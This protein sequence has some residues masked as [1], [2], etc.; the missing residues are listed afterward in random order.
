[1]INILNSIKKN[2]STLKSFILQA[3]LATNIT[4]VV[5]FAVIS[6]V[7]YRLYFGVDFTDEAFYIVIP[8]RFAMGATP[9]IDEINLLQTASFIFIP[10]IKIYYWI[11]GSTEGIVLFTRRFYLT[12]MIL[13][14]S[15]TYFYFKRFIRWQ[16]A[17]L[18]SFTCVAFIPYN[19]PSFSYNTLSYSLFT[20]GCITAIGIIFNNDRP[21]YF[22]LSGLCHGLAVLAYPTI[23]IPSLIFLIIIV[24]IKKLKA[25]FYYVLGGLLIA[26]VLLPLV[27]QAG[28]DNL[29]G[30]YTYFRSFGVQG[31]SVDK[32]INTILAFWNTY[33]Y[34]VSIIS[35]LV[36]VYLSYKLNY[37]SAIYVLLLL[38]ILPLLPLLKGSYI[39]ASLLYI[40]YY[41]LLAPYLLLFFGK[42]QKVRQVFWVLWVPSFIAGLTF[43]WSS[44]NGYI[45]AGLGFFQGSLV[46]AYFIYRL[47]SGLQISKSKFH[48]IIQIISP[49]MILVTLV[50]FQYTSV[51]RDDP[52]PE[53]NTRVLAGPYSGMF[54]TTEKNQYL[55]ELSDDL[56]SISKPE[57]K[58][59]FYDRFP[60][61]YLLT[62]MIPAT[63]TCW[64]QPVNVF[65]NL[66]RQLNVDYYNKY[67][68]EPDIVVRMKKVFYSA[69]ETNEL[70][71]PPNDSLN[72][73]V[74]SQYKEILS[75]SNYSIFQKVGRS[76]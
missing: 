66:N 51:Y 37:K 29:V 3:N 27:F 24:F 61:G 72:N 40:S 23:L 19:V 45:A 14:S 58:V 70:V 74:E 65:P 76:N 13:I 10:F 55:T 20:L 67:D 17:L 7:F 1:M 30:V 59:L 63:N 69:Q 52:I 31:G 8:Y 62:S 12:Y 46:T 47:L 44:S 16:V 35:S 15:L 68:M 42:D 48:E 33:P 4:L 22:L 28:P 11:V 49:I 26:G 6:G 18:I 41:A 2:K 54:T 36:V 39:S 5:L 38:P 57:L 64:L 53:L 34:K 75:T 50:C 71:Y 25:F 60:A 56:E 43:A 73:M 9:F 32:L 21:Y